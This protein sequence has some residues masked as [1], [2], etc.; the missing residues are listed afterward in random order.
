MTKIVLLSDA[1]VSNLI[2]SGIEITDSVPTII[3]TSYFALCSAQ[4]GGGINIKKGT[5]YVQKTCI[6]GCYASVQGNAIYSLAESYV[7]LSSVS[8]C[9]DREI[10]SD[11]S[12]DFEQLTAEIIN[13]NSTYSRC[14]QSSSIQAAACT[15]LSTSYNIYAHGSG[16]YV[17]QHYDPKT[18]PSHFNEIFINNTLTKCTMFL[19]KPKPIYMKGCV[20]KDNQSPF[21]LE[22]DAGNF[23]SITFED[24]VFMDSSPIRTSVSY[25]TSTGKISIPGPK[26]ETAICQ[27]FPEQRSCELK[28][29]TLS[30][31]QS[32]ALLMPFAG[33]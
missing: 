1:H 26:E 17:F 33:E 8:R 2:S 21:F 24:V 15:K 18:N 31:A 13:I 9:A 20:F 19:Y 16:A 6:Y 11:D 27:M 10:G 30:F 29:I 3:S 32:L 28:R 4:K 23:P 22:F 25:T 12:I 7:N 14:S 5:L